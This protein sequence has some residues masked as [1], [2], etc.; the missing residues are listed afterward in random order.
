M[1]INTA[2]SLVDLCGLLRQNQNKTKS[3]L[4]VER[5]FRIKAKVKSESTELGASD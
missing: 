5:K 1:L 4:I 3:S 2:L